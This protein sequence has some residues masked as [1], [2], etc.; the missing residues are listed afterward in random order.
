ML[1][2]VPII[3]R[4]ESISLGMSQPQPSSSEGISSIGASV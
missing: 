3:S 2:I 1:S 4:I